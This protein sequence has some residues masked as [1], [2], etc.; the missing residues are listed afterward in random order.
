MNYLTARSRQ[1]LI[2]SEQTAES[3]TGSSEELKMLSQQLLSEAQENAILL[4]GERAKLQQLAIAESNKAINSI[5]QDN[6][7]RF[8]LSFPWI[9]LKIAPVVSITYGSVKGVDSNVKAENGI[10]EL[11]DYDQ[12]KKYIDKKTGLFFGNINA[13]LPSPLDQFDFRLASLAA[14]VKGQVNPARI[15]Q[16]KQ[17]IQLP[18][19]LVL[20][21]RR[22]YRLSVRI[23]QQRFYESRA[24]LPPPVRPRL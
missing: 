24:R 11:V 18:R 2:A 4:A 10:V 6:K 16:E 8:D 20:P 9:K 5:Y 17:T 3:K 1:L 19:P 14:P 12:S 15:M 23:G 22:T 13:R 21:L 7:G